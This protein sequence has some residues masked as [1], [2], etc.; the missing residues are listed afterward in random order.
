MV[1]LPRQKWEANFTL[2]FYTIP[3]VGIN[4]SCQLCWIE[5]YLEVAKSPSVFVCEDVPT[6]DLHV[7]Q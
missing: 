6:E 3:L 2:F 5:K 7:N 1:F 4:F